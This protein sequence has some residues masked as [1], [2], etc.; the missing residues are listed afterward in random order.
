VTTKTISC[1]L[2]LAFG[3]SEKFDI[4]AAPIMAVIVSGDQPIRDL[5]HVADKTVKEMARSFL[6][7]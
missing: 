6:D 4:D 2:T 1:D 3:L 5:T 7:L